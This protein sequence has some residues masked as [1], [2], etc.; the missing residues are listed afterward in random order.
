[1]NT[2]LHM[3]KGPA[4]NPVE[5]LLANIGLEKAYAVYNGTS[6]R[7]EEKIIRDIVGKLVEY[8]KLSGKQVDFVKSL[9][10]KIEDRAKAE[11]NLP[12]VPTVE[13]R[14]TVKGKVVSIKESMGPFPGYK[15][16]IVHDDG[17]K[18]HGTLPR[19]IVNVEKGDTVEFV[20]TVK[21][22]RD[23]KSFGFFSRPTN[24]KIVK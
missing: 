12:P 11:A 1:M 2:A 16:L 6:N 3:V 20:A 5:A 4:V 8:G 9:L 15:M 14:V 23:D 19:S 13:G 24:A 7:Y 21:P 22:S 10:G 17:Y 18:L